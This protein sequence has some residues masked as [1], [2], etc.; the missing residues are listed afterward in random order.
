MVIVGQWVEGLDGV[1]RPMIRVRVTRLDGSPIEDAFLVDVGADR[2]VLSAHFFT[3]LRLPGRAPDAG[4][5]LEGISGKCT[6]RL[7]QRAFGI[8]SRRWSHN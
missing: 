2:T 5:M 7:D 8:A 4:M 3:G 1:T 6:V